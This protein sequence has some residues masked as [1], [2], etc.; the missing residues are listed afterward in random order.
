MDWRN[1]QNTTADLFRELGCDVKVES[2][3]AG[4][5]SNHAIDVLVE[6]RNFGIS[7]TWIVECKHWRRNVTKEKVMALRSIS[8]DLG[9]DRAII[10]SSSGFQ[11]GAI[12]A[13][14]NTNITLTDLEGLRE[15]TAQ[16]LMSLSLLDLEAR[17]YKVKH[18][19]NSLYLSKREDANHWSSKPIH[20]SVD[21]RTVYGCLGR[22]VLLHYGLERVRLGTPPYNY[23]WDESGNKVISTRSIAEFVAHAKQEMNEAEALLSNQLRIIK[24]DV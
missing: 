24:D 6:F 2:T 15:I 17:G 7:A 13:A 14:T 22:L 20:E 11:A 5:R 10:V 4:A 19:L 1:L 8:E 21:G 23:A 3:V 12:R 18:G 16:D 9:A